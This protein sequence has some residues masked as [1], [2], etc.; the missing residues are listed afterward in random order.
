MFTETRKIHLIEEVLK[1]SDETTL[2]EL[3]NV[4]KKSKSQRK[5][6]ESAYDFVGLW[7]KRDAEIIEKAIEDGGEQINADDWK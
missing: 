2:H 7:N 6:K 3:E 1:V 5:K 4:L